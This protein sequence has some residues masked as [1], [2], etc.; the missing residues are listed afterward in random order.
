M[1][2]TSADKILSVLLTNGCITEREPSM[3]I[4]VIRETDQIISCQSLPNDLL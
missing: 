4:D 3:S 2:K 1:L